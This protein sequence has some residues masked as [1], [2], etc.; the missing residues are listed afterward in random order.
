MDVQEAAV[1]FVNRMKA[2]PHREGIPYFVHP[3]FIENH[4][5]FP[6]MRVMLDH[7]TEH[8][9]KQKAHKDAEPGHAVR[10]FTIYER[11]VAKG[12]YLMQVV[13]EGVGP[14]SLFTVQV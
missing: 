3:A 13:Y 7:Y 11:D 12:L 6:E 9:L 1:A 2:W 4:G 5:I 10:A 8:G 14:C